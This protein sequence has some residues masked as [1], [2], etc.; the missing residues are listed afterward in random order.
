MPEPT[1][2]EALARPTYSFTE[3]H[4]ILKQAIE[5]ARNLTWQQI[6]VPSLAAIG[7]LIF[8]WINDYLLGRLDLQTGLRSLF[9]SL[10][11]GL[12]LY[13]IVAIIRAPFIVLAR[14]H[15]NL[16]GLEERLR[17]AEQRPLLASAPG[18]MPAKK[19]EIICPDCSIVDMELTDRMTLVE[20]SGCQTVLADFYMMPVE[21]S[22]RW[23][24]V[25]SR[26][27]FYDREFETHALVKEGV[28]LHSDSVS[29]AFHRGETKSLVLALL[30]PNGISGYEHHSYET[31]TYPKYT[32]LKPK[33]GKLDYENCYVEVELFG[34]YMDQLRLK[35]TFWYEISKPSEWKVRQVT[36]EELRN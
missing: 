15:Q 22:E 29:L 23:V 19:P 3:R 26:I 33:V 5:D 32:H 8:T 16:L 11:I 24:E 7:N 34:E 10:L 21:D 17:A 18:L 25:R 6:G 12:I 30:S 2:P 4:P 20:G 31:G 27:T 14:N 1:S 35:R 9:F 28:W 13:V 36:D